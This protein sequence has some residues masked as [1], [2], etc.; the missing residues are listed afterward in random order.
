MSPVWCNRRHCWVVHH[1]WRRA[2]ILATGPTR[3][4]A[5]NA[6]EQAWADGQQRVAAVG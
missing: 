4:A 1:P 2:D 5:I 6:A 3:E